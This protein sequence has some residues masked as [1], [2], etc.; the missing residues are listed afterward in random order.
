[1]HPGNV[2]SGLKGVVISIGL[3][4]QIEPRST[5]RIPVPPPLVIS[6]GPRAGIDPTDKE[7]DTEVVGSPRTPGRSPTGSPSPLDAQ[8]NLSCR[9]RC[10]ATQCYAS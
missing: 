2:L 9:P 6:A 1:M 4:R 5:R 10:R 3:A 7:H 8:R